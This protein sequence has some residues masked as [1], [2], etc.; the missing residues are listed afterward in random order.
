MPELFFKGKEFVYNHHLSV[1][2]RPLIPDSA[3]SIAPE[4]EIPRLDENLIIHGDNLHGLKALLPMYAGR[5]DCVYIDPPYNTGEQSWDYNDN[6]NSPLMKEWFK[7]NPVNDE[8]MLRHDK[9]C[10]MMWPRLNLLRELLKESGV[11]F[12]SINDEEVHN[13]R[14][15]MDEIFG[16]DARIAQLI[17]KSRQNKDNRN[18][19]GVSVDHEY[20]LAYGKKLRGADRKASSY[21]NPDND[22]RGD[23]TSENMVGLATREER[24]N[25]HYDLIDP[26]TNINYG[27][28]DQGWRY[29]PDTMATLIAEERILWPSQPTGRPREKKFLNKLSATTNTSSII[30]AGIFTRHGT[31]EVE[32]IFGERRFKFPKPSAL[33]AQLIEQGCP[34]DGIVLDSFAGSGTTAHAVLRQNERDGGKRRFILVEAEEYADRTTADRVRRV[35][36][37]Y[38]FEGRQREELLRETITYR[39]FERSERLRS[40]ISSIENIENLRFDRITKEVDGGVLVVTGEKTFTERADGLGGSFTYCTLGEPL[41]LDAIL[42]GE[43]LPTFEQ[44]GAWLF[45]T[46][47]NEAFD[48]ANIDPEQYYVGESRA[49]HVWLR[50]KPDLEFLKSRDA[51]LT[52]AWATELAEKHPIGKTHKR[53]LVFA[54]AKFA[55]NKQLLPLGVEHAP[56]PF[57]LF[58]IER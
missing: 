25:L 10:C 22:P 48:P 26:E 3:K 31:D 34:P 38:S 36:N 33:I 28:P 19:S 51:A 47:T 27:C 20:I 24:P 6:V 2:F 42:S 58:K 5:I 16:E 41:D 17:W 7:E 1:P 55:A 37:G 56:L 14:A 9:W 30:G 13:L 39:V 21:S 52:L 15:M 35:I 43:T 49:Y 40:R 50:Y 54:P 4:G 53:H 11:I 8:D 45:H 46:A 12:V 57:S 23:W 44:L 18:K 29:E 32:A